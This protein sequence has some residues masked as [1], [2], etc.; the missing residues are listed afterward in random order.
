M[1]IIKECLAPEM[2]E[3]KANKQFSTKFSRTGSTSTHAAKLVQYQMKYWQRTRI[4]SNW[5]VCAKFAF[6]G[7]KMTLY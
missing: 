1:T 2:N 5:Y 4:L 3:L 7:M 6:R